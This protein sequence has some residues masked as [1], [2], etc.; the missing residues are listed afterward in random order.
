MKRI[1]LLS[2]LSLGL[3]ACGSHE[4]K[5]PSPANQQTA[6]K[7]R[8][9]S[10]VE[11]LYFHGK[12]RCKTC[13]AIEQGAKEVVE[14]RFADA[15]KQGTVAFRNIDTSEKAN[16]ALAAQYGATWSSLFVVKHGSGKETA[17]NLTEYAF[18]HARKSPDAFKDSLARKILTLLPE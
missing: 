12:Q 3:C 18:A 6:A 4:S 1:L 14:S 15:V 11:V 8:Q 13:I 9:A 7:P 10:R 17:D 16:E 2:I 5:N